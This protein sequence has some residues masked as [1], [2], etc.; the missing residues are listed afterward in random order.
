MAAHGEPMTLRLRG[1]IG[2]SPMFTGSLTVYA[3][4]THATGADLAGDTQQS[5]LRLRIAA[6]AFADQ[7]PPARA[8]RKLDEI[9]DDAGNIY[10]VQDVDPRFDGGTV[11]MF[12]VTATGDT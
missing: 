10:V 11:L 7:S 5:K 2:D 12:M 8:P 9:E 6:Q 3:K 4:R 1:G